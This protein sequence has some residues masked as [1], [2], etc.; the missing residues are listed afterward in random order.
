MNFNISRRAFLAG[1]A[2]A[3]A[4][5]VM[6][7]FAVQAQAN[8]AHLRL[9]ETTD[10][11]VAVYPYDYFADAPNDTMGLARTATLIEAIRAE[12]GNSVLIDNGDVIQGNPLGDYVAY[13]RGV[14][15]K[16]HPTIAAM[17]TGS[18]SSTSRWP[19]PTSR[20]SR[21]IWSRASSPPI[22]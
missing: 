7:P 12:A 9:I 20:S 19:A 17:N 18:N 22:P 8:Q 6:H 2:S 5:I 13:E 16:P 15:D 10:L 11:H 21:P 1:S 14:D 4:L 3:G